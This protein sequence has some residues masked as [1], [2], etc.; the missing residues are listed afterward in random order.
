MK[1]LGF[2][3]SLGI[4][5]DKISLWLQ[6][7]RNG[8]LNVIDNTTDNLSYKKSSYIISPIV[9]VI[10]FP[11]A[12][13][14]GLIP[15][16]STTLMV[17]ISPDL[18]IGHGTE[19]GYFTELGKKYLV[20]AKEYFVNIK[21]HG[22]FFGIFA[23]AISIVVIPVLLLMSI[24]FFILIILDLLGWFV[25]LIRKFV[26]GSSQAMANKSGDNAAFAVIMPVLL[27]LF[28]PLYLVLLLIPKI[29]THEMNT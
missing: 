3:F 23:L 11:I 25:S 18:D 15:K 26:V 2:I 24:A 6:S 4:I 20:L 10:M 16:W 5:L 7:K 12:L 17:G 28:V 13:L 27:T 1:L 8:V 19:H 9:A 21:E 14:F 22:F 29:A